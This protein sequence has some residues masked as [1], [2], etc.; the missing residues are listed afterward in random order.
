[1]INLNQTNIIGIDYD[2]LFIYFCSLTDFMVIFNTYHI[3]F[4][5]NMMLVRKK[6]GLS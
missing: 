5:D 3:D 4:G 1:M 6:K 2:L